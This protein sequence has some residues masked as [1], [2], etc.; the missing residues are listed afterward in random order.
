MD[1]K[2]HTELLCPSGAR[3]TVGAEVG[4]CMYM[5]GARM[6][7]FIGDEKPEYRVCAGARKF[8][9]ARELEGCRATRAG[10]AV[11]IYMYDAPLVDGDGAQGMDGAH[12][13]SRE[14]NTA[15]ADESP[16]D[17]AASKFVLLEYLGTSES[18][19]INQLLHNTQIVIEWRYC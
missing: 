1:I 15:P 6:R 3:R 14:I 18:L 13:L 10:R 17:A 8:N 12:A 4:G 11:Q 16:D 19:Q 2:S 9:A 7:F 5:R